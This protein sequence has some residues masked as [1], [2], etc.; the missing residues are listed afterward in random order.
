MFARCI[1]WGNGAGRSSATTTP[2]RIATALPNS[3][4]EITS[5][6]DPVKSLAPATR[7]AAGPREAAKK[8]LQV[9]GRLKT[10]AMNDTGRRYAAL[11]EQRKQAR[12]V[13][14][15]RFEGM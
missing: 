4:R 9:L 3:D 2:S 7:T 5:C 10:G 11:L 15:Y 1:S 13:A 14:W 12:E 6:G 8:A